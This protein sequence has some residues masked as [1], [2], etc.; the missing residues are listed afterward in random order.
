MDRA[1]TPE[2]ADLQYAS[3]AGD[4]HKELQ[5]LA[6]VWGDVYLRQPC[7]ARA[8]QRVF[9]SRVR[10]GEEPLDVGVYPWKQVSQVVA[11][12]FTPSKSR[13]SYPT[14]TNVRPRAAAAGPASLLSPPS[15][16]RANSS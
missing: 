7:L 4:L 11:V 15:S 10:R 5:K 6:P 9:E 12:H 14:P 16:R 2:R 3:R 8:A 13:S 1:V